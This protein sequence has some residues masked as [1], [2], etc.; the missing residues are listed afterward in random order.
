MSVMQ[1]S[2]KL[3]LFLFAAVVALALLVWSQVSTRRTERRD[4]R[5]QPHL[6][7]VSATS[8]SSATGT[9]TPCPPQAA[10][11]TVLRRESETPAAVVRVRV[12]WA[13][14]AGP[15][16]RV[17]VVATPWQSSGGP[18]FRQGLL[19]DSEGVALFDDLWP[20]SI[21]LR[22]D[23]GDSRVVS[24]AAGETVDVN[25]TVPRG[26]R[27]QGVVVDWN[28]RPVSGASI[29]LTAPHAVDEGAVVTTSDGAGR[30][31]IESALSSQRVQ[32]R[33]PGFTPSDVRSVVERKVSSAEFRLVLPQIGRAVRGV[34]L[35]PHDLPVPDAIVL[36]GNEGDG[37]L[38]REKTD[39]S[40]SFR[41]EGAHPSAQPLCVLAPEF[42]RHRQIVDLASEDTDL[43]IR[44][45][46]GGTVFGRV[47]DR[48]GVAVGGA[49]VMVGRFGD[50]L[51]AMARAGE[52]G[53]YTL[54]AL[55]AGTVKV[56]VTGSGG[57]TSRD[58]DLSGTEPVRWDPVL[59]PALVLHGQLL[60]RDGNPLES[61]FVSA[62]IPGRLRH[63]PQQTTAGGAFEFR[64]CQASGHTLTAWPEGDE[65]ARV[66][67]ATDAEPGEKRL[68]VRLPAKNTESFVSGI[69]VGAGGEHVS[70]V[71]VVLE[72]EGGA[73]ER[74]LAEPD[75]RFRFGPVA[76]GTYS[77]EASAARM[78]SLSLGP[79]EI[80]TGEQLDLGV[81]HLGAPGQLL[82]VLRG[83]EAMTDSARVA[84]LSG[85]SSARVPI[86]EGKASAEAL[87]AGRYRM[88]IMGPEFADVDRS[89]RIR[90][91]EAATV[92][93][94]LRQ[95]QLCSVRF[96]IPPGVKPESL[97][98]VTL[99]DTSGEVVRRAR[100]SR[101]GDR[102]EF[103]PRLAPG[104]YAVR[105]ECKEALITEGELVVPA[106]GEPS[107]AEFALKR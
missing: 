101:S 22:V 86:R 3:Q 32:A 65:A 90:P 67:V 58:L 70:G 24:V 78:T 19:T 82:L 64:H 63:V 102:Y 10:P 7:E 95:G 62:E 57:G 103:R 38:I 21:G 54:T 11:V 48:N 92:D 9:E 100:I 89:F 45:Q 16:G 29:F 66:V 50:L 4:G 91:G 52:D 44:L 28:D 39:E 51:G 17:R 56:S 88:R 79:C 105:A 80:R 60:D 77:L 23:G 34:V 97:L 81:L 47:Q 33:A 73:T 49:L 93:I 71:R 75:G 40:G 15:A 53:R 8:S 69:V 27:V 84:Y 36:L 6:P 37:T 72:S 25:L 87:P 43:V 14:D 59:V 98:E 2:T 18:L 20:G 106:H 83:S 42:A 55:A 99:L 12:S 61:W 1:G 41:I 74:V 94:E 5:E 13:G 107:A 46:A 31:A 76:P 35:N 26:F 104:R 68:V 30:F 85:A 96:L